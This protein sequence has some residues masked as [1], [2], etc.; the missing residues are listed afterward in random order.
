MFGDLGK[1]MKMAGEMKR[2]M[3]ELK[4]KLAASEYTAEAG[5]GMVRVTVNGRLAL[6]ELHISPEALTEG[7][8]DAGLLEDLL[9]AAVASAQAQAAEAAEAAMKELTG[10]MDLP[11][12]DGLF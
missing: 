6:T 7:Q 2:K 4:E 3:P 10:G 8:A 11:G 12:M 1:I 5:G 9:K